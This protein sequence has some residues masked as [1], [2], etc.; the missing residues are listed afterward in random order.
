MGGD[1][2]AWQDLYSAVT[3]RL[4]AFLKPKVSH[5]DCE[6]IILLTWE[7]VFLKLH[8]FDPARDFRAWVFA[9][10]MNAYRDRLRR[11]K[12]Q[13]HPLGD[14]NWRDEQPCPIDDSDFQQKLE[15]L[16]ICIDSLDSQE[17]T[18]IRFRFWE[19]KTHAQIAQY[20]GMRSSQIRSKCHRIVTKLA[21]CMGY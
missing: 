8:T 2:N 19:A 3:P 9:I 17:R 7:K 5:A 12:R 10:A 21:T 16:N 6:E 15:R 11:I 14:L 1:A 20:A 4:F 18:I 13:L